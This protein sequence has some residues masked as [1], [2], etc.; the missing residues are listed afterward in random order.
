MQINVSLALSLFIGIGS[1]AVAPTAASAQT[2]AATPAAKMGV[3]ANTDA[4]QVLLSAFYS[5]VSTSLPVGFQSHTVAVP[6]AKTLSSFVVQMPGVDAN[7]IAVYYLNGLTEVWA[8]GQTPLK[9]DIKT[10]NG[11]LVVSSAEWTGRAPGFAILEIKA[12]AAGIRKFYAVNLGKAVQAP[13]GKP[14]E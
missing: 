2:P 5:G 11:Q 7:R 13:G 8:G 1:L 14:T 4:G 6:K 10:E 9:A 12:D 3:W